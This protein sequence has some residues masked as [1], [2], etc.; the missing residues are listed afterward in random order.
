MEI[1]LVTFPFHVKSGKSLI[2]PSI[3]TQAIDEEGNDKSLNEGLFTV[4]RIGRRRERRETLDG[5]GQ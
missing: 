5:G 3:I 1:G 2:I 4:R